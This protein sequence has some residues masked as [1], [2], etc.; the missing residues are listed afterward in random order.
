M[1]T[2]SGGLQRPKLPPSVFN[3]PPSCLASPTAPARKEKIEFATQSYFDKKDKL[4]SFTDFSPE[5]GLYKKYKDLLVSRCKEKVVYLFMNECGSE[6]QIVITVEDKS[7]LCSP[8]TLTAHKMGEKIAF[9]KNVVGPNNGFSRY[10]QFYEAV[11]FSL[12]YQVSSNG[13]LKKVSERLDIVEC[14]DSMTEDRKKVGFIKRQVALLRTKNFV[15]KDY[16]SAMEMYPH[17]R[18]EQLRE[19]LVLPGK[20]KIRGII[21]S[22]EAVQ[23]VKET[24]V[25]Q[26]ARASFRLLYVYSIQFNLIF[27]FLF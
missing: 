13:H 25:W 2:A 20:S 12:N 4:T 3:L 6:S 17:C 9:P 7:T 5:K 16:C 15:M 11:N 27:R 26:M 8:L 1:K 21:S 22:T 23:V 24:C 14:L 19:F 18:Y 10:S